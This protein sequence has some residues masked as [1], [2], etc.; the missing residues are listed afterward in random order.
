MVTAD[1][2]FSVEKHVGVVTLNRP[3]A[4]NALNFSMIQALYQQL[5]QWQ[6]DDDI[7]A[8][9]IQAA[10]GKAFCAGGDIK[11]LYET[12]KS[13]LAL[14]LSFFE[15][16]YRLN[17]LIHDYP[18][19]YIAIM[20]GMTMGGG[21]GVSLHGS[22]PVATQQFVF[23]MPETT[24]GFFP[25]IGA[26]YLLA[27][28]PDETGIYLGLTGERLNAEE[29]FELGLVKHVV[30]ATD[31]SL[32]LQALVAADL[33]R[34]SAQ[35]VTACLEAFTK[36]KLNSS[37][38]AHRS[39]INQCFQYNSM[40]SI[41][42]ALQEMDDAWST[43]HLNLLKQRSP[44]SLCVT[45]KQLKAA[46][47]LSLEACLAMDMT[48][49]KHFMQGHDFYEGVRALLIDKDQTPRWQPAHWDATIDQ[50]V[51]DYFEP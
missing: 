24:I 45:L 51:A 23:A 22:H 9:V 10:E 4:L 50:M 8:V 21:V 25:D 18:K 31:V 30:Q 35:K 43:N 19:P 41:L 46:K 29:A 14:A 34:N 7:H 16:E 2:L 39:M 28:C 5:L 38:H 20:N 36:P 26:S 6:H 49:V 13:N 33:S 32:L 12:G 40:Q 3:K 17:Q 37:I 15:Q 47:A 44:L 1:V 42:Q 11:W 48:L 27:H